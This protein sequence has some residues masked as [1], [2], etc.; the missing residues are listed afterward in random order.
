MKGPLEG[1][2]RRKCTGRRGGKGGDG[3]R[4]MTGM[5]VVEDLF[6]CFGEVNEQQKF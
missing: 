6:F 4:R 2:K 3:K 1:K 5:V